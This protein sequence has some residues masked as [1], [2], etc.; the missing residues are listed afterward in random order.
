MNDAVAEGMGDREQYVSIATPEGTV[1][2]ILREVPNAAAAVIMLGGATGGMHGPAGSYLDLA[3]L[4]QREGITSLRLDYR[5]ANHLDACVYDTLAG[6]D[7]LQQLGARR[8][9]LIGWSFGGA[10]VITAGAESDAVVGV[11]T[12]ASQTHGTQAVSRLGQRDLLLCHG[13]ADATLPDRCSQDIY[14]RASCPKELKL[15]PNGNHGITNYRMELLDT[16]NTWAQNILASARAAG[17]ESSPTA[18]CNEQPARRVET[19]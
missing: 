17:V 19:S 12:V 11:A 7:A 15:F 5:H 9:A 18:A 13:T 6:I 10:V 4:L 8:V 2:G 16:L 1:V 3:R 14:A